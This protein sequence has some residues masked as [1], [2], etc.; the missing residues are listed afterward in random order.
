VEEEVAVVVV[1]LEEVVAAVFVAV[2][3]LAVAVAVALTASAPPGL[4][5]HHGLGVVAVVVVAGLIALRIA[6]SIRAI[7]AAIRCTDPAAAVHG[8]GTTSRRISSG[9]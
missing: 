8:L 7:K 6:P 5:L 9:A 1:I 2:A 3:G 4:T